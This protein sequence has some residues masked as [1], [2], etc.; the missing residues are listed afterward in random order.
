MTRGPSLVERIGEWFSD[1]FGV[2][3]AI[4]RE[5]LSPR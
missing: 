1:L 4:V 5:A 3:G 2:L